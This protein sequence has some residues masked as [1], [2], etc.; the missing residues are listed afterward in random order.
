MMKT[1]TRRYLYIFWLILVVFLPF[2][3]SSQTRE[4]KALEARREQLQEEIRQINSLLFQKAREKK[5][6]LSEV[7][8][9]HQKIKVREALIRV[10]NQQANLLNRQISTNLKEI[11]GL[12]SELESLKAHYAEMIRKSYRNKSQQSRLMF[13]LSSSNFLQAYKRLQYMKQYT[14]YRKAQAEK[15]QSKTT[16]LQSLN[17]E[18]IAQRKEKEKLIAENKNAKQLLEQEK[19]QQETLI[20][21]IRKKEGEYTA[22]V[23]EKQQE[24]DKLDR[25]IERLIR[26]AIA[27]AN[28]KAGNT[29]NTTTFALTP[30]AKLIA[31]DFS[32]NKGKL[33]WP[34][35]KGIK[36]TAFGEYSDPVYPGLKRFNSGVVIA[37]E[38]GAQAR[39]VFKGEVSAIIVVPGGNKAVQLRHGNYITTYYNLSK[40]YVKKGDKITIR[41][42]LGEIFTSPSSGKT[43]L[44]FF[45]YKN[46][47]R[48]NPEHWIY[49]M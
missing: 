26:E 6:V 7:E 30:E 12:R 17:E 24:A 41:E 35:E 43:E 3:G 28:K 48:L 40:V 8:D 29:S 31:D 32:A 4:Q 22:Q 2:R 23:K 34:V 33:I 11:D 27:E 19:A 13:L 44:K 14:R 16:T 10:T 38:K 46:T 25:Q 45:L 15:I 42:V 9:L 21:S 47:D 5:N 18:L 39:A 1:A 20:A 36:S 49:R 37:T